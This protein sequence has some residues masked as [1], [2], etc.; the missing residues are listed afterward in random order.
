MACDPSGVERDHSFGALGD[1]PRVDLWGEV[2]RVYVTRPDPVRRDFT[3]LPVLLPGMEIEWKLVT[4]QGGTTPTWRGA[5]AE[6]IH[7]MLFR[8]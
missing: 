1:E 4:H 8:L 5:T 7:E 2:R 3:H 6:E